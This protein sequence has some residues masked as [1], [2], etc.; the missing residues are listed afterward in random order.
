MS[1]AERA[2]IEELEQRVAVL[3]RLVTQVEAVQRDVLQLAA[4]YSLI[5]DEVHDQVAREI[6]EA[7]GGGA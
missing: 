7:A 1:E 2:R 3:T 5:G 4:C 6:R